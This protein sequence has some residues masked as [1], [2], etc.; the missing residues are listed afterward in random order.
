MLKDKIAEWGHKVKTMDSRRAEVDRELAPLVETRKK[1]EAKFARLAGARTIDSP[2]EERELQKAVL[3]IEELQRQRRTVEQE[4]A[5][6]GWLVGELERGGR[7]LFQ[8]GAEGILAAEAEIT[9]LEQ[10]E[11]EVRKQLQQ[12]EAERPV[13]AYHAEQ[14]G[15]AK[16]LG[17]FE[18]RITALQERQTNLAAGRRQAVWLAARAREAFVGLFI[19]QRLTAGEAVSATER[20]HLEAIRG[21]LESDRQM[22]AVARELG[23]SLSNSP[24]VGEFQLARLAQA[25]GIKVDVPYLHPQA[26]TLS[27]RDAK[28]LGETLARFASSAAAGRPKPLPA[29]DDATGILAM[30]ASAG[31]RLL[32]GQSK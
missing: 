31:K 26:E 5:E 21:A 25:I 23:V 15:D 20:G 19:E 28:R 11:A 27:E 3:R 32:S 2:G 16:D 24:D 9:A 7:G 6:A 12:A 29:P 22:K 18:A 14:Q 10:K 8:D 4:R 1:L 17:Q 30:C 13:V